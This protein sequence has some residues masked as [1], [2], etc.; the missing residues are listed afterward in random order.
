MA[1]LAESD[2]VFFAEGTDS[3]WVIIEVF[4]TVV[5]FEPAFWGEGVFLEADF[6]DDFIDG[7][8]GNDFDFAVVVFYPE[9]CGGG[10]D[11]V[12]TEQVVGERKR[13]AHAFCCIG[14]SEETRWRVG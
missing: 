14:N 1:K 7:L 10:G 3:G 2:V 6:S 4:S 9:R 12:F 11:V 13:A 8:D 5:Y